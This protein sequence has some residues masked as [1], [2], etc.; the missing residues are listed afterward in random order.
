MTKLYQCDLAY[1]HTA[2]FETMAREAAHEITDRLQSS[3]V[4]VRKVVG[5]L[6][7]WNG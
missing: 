4:P 1:V 2:V 5:R 6:D 3:R 7:C